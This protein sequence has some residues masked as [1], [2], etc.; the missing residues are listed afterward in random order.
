MTLQRLAG[1]RAVER[2]LTEDRH[3]H[4]PGCGH[5]KSGGEHDTGREGAQDTGGLEAGGRSGP[6]VQRDLLDRAMASPGRPLPDTVRTRA[7]SFYHNDFSSAVLHEGPVAQR[8]T[9]AMGAQA[10]T[11]GTHVFLPSGKA[12][13]AELI[14]HELSHVDKNLRG[15]RETGTGNGG[16]VTVTDPGQPS[17]RAAG[18][19]GA[20]FAAGAATAPSVTAQGLHHEAPHPDGATTAQRSVAG[21]ASGPVQRATQGDAMDLDSS[22]DSLS[23]GVFNEAMDQFERKEELDSVRNMGPQERG[24][25][26]QRELRRLFKEA[27]WAVE[28]KKGE[29]FE[30][31]TAGVEKSKPRDFK[32]QPEVQR[33]RWI[34]TVTKHYLLKT[35]GINP[36]E[37]QAAIGND[38]RIII[39]ANDRNAN[40]HLSDL[41]ENR[42]V[43]DL[44]GYMLGNSGPATN[45]SSQQAKDETDRINRHRDKASGMQNE[46]AEANAGINTGLTSGTV[47]ARDGGDGTHAELRILKKNNGKTPQHLAGTKRPCA[48]CFAELYPEGSPKDAGGKDLVRPGRFYSS[49]ESNQH[50]PEHKDSV[51]ETPE[52]RARKAFGRIMK[53]VPRTHETASQSGGTLRGYGS[54][55]E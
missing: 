29:E 7:E 10:M 40:G 4:G 47:I 54:E 25:K 43:L 17:E 46:P 37:V 44:L 20:A 22:E 21:P 8:A 6:A 23:D 15:E 55:S 28:I 16:G 3:S 48:S 2:L 19:D 30:A 9:E 11:V 27:G 41:M 36:V 31:F 49:R 50:F 42:G 1:N 13:D 26:F 35:A 39:S 38:G 45:R 53:S 32:E 52:E 5:G 51:D 24:K 33:L 18:S 34:S 12:Q 14:G